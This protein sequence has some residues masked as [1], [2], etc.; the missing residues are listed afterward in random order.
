MFYV[1]QRYVA[2]VCVCVCGRKL[3]IETRDKWTYLHIIRIQTRTDAHV[4]FFCKGVRE[5]CLR[6]SAC[7]SFIWSVSPFSWW[8]GG[9][10]LKWRL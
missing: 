1:M 6:V 5:V 9:S 4:S 2:C 3:Q 8:S 10:C 7:K